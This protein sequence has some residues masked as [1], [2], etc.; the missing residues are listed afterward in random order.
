MKKKQAS[1][2]AQ[3]IAFARA[4]ESSKPEG[5]RICYDPMARRLISPAFYGLC[6]LF[7][8]YGERKGPGVLAFLATRHRCMDDYLQTC[9]VDGIEQ[10]VILGAGLDSRAYRIA[11]HRA[12]LCHCSCDRRVTRCNA[13][14]KC[15]APGGRSFW[16]WAGCCSSGSC[17]SN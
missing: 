17:C 8:G 11:N 14:L 12:H 6:R 16:W 5:E 15:V 13:L 3:G 10:L 1:I 2:T 4:L 7:A 9:L